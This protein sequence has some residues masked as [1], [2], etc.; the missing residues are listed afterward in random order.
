VSSP[1]YPNKAGRRLFRPE[2]WLGIEFRHLAA[3]EAVAEEASFNRAGSRLGYTQSAISQQVAVLERAV[4]QKLIDRPGGRSRVALTPAGHLLLLHAEA[5]GARLAAAYADLTAM[6][7]GTIGTM[8]VGTFHSLGGT[9]VPQI[10]HEFTKRRPNIAVDLTELANDQELLTLL[11]Q[12]ALDVV[13]AHLPLP[14]GPYETTPLL[15]DDYVLVVERSAARRQQRATSIEQIAK[16]RL[17]GM[18]SCRS[19]DPFLAHLHSLGLKA[20]FAHRADSIQMIEGMVVAG[21]GSAIVPRLATD[22]MGAQVAVIGLDCLDLPQRL[23]AVVRNNN[24][25]RES[26]ISEIVAVAQLVSARLPQLHIQTL[27]QAVA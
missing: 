14:P 15:T 8:R 17:V 22:L 10:L 3:L 9:L 2:R 19:C 7:Q 24:R 16:I 27:T 11:E 12:A 1:T 21:L 13:F 25:I 4:G 5:I 20:E 23:V 6:E 18:K 26:S